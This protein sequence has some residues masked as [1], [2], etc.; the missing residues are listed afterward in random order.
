MI[1]GNAYHEL[2]KNPGKGKG[3]PS[4]FKA[5]EKESIKL[6]LKPYVIAK[7]IFNLVLIC[8]LS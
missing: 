7:E 8:N 5:K 3:M 2:L 6:P 1:Q 4:N